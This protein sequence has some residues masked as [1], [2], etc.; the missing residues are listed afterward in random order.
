[1]KIRKMLSA[2]LGMAIVTTML[3]AFTVAQAASEIQLSATAAYNEAKKAVELTISY[4]GFDDAVAY[5]IDD[6]G[7][8]NVN[9]IKVLGFEI[10]NDAGLTVGSSQ[11]KGSGCAGI[12]KVSKAGV[13]AFLATSFE[14]YYG[15]DSGVLCKVYYKTDPSTPITF[16]V[17]PLA[18]GACLTGKVVDSDFKGDEEPKLL[19]ATCDF[20][21]STPP[22]EEVKAAF[23]K[24]AATKYE[25]E[26]VYNYGVGGTVTVP[27]GKNVT[28]VTF[29]ISNGIDEP[30]HYDFDFGKNISAN[31]SFGLNIGNVPK[32]VTLTFSNL[33]VK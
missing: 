5:T 22:A 23:D 24:D 15:Q 33:K 8:E 31:V 26:T 14:D 16:T 28:G 1:M 3:S 6:D 11:T 29:D 25:Y 30:Y 19:G 21:K 20:N 10:T 12:G 13:Y 27:E 32:D 17:T 7:V 9:G 2:F 18:Q 4:S